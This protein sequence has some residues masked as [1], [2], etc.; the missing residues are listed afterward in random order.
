MRRI[1]LGVVAAAAIA[2]PLVA[3]TAANAT[4]AVENGIG[5]VDKG[6][7]QTAL[8]WNNAAFD[9]GVGSLKF[10]TS[11]EKVNA[12]YKMSCFNGSTGAIDAEVSHTIISQPGTTTVTATP[13]LNSGNG[14]QITG[15]NLTGQTSGFT[16]TG[17][18]TVRTVPCPDGSFSYM[19]LGQ[20][21][22][23]GKTQVTGGLKVNG[24]DL[25]NTPVLAPVA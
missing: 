1:I 14:K 18:A 16:A 13:V 15:F 12:D 23:F 3:A 5:H 8:G 4:V 19:N 21:D 10:T 17:G 11:A 6:D 9:K 22:L 7:V 24:I 20:G 25:P 2:T